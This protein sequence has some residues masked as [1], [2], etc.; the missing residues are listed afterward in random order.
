MNNSDAWGRGGAANGAKAAIVSDR[1][2]MCLGCSDSPGNLEEKVSQ[3]ETMLKKLQDDLQKVPWL[4][5]IFSSFK[6]RS[7]WA[8][9]AEPAGRRVD[10]E[11]WKEWEDASSLI[12]APV[13]LSS[14]QL[15]PCRGS[16]WKHSNSLYLSLTLLYIYTFSDSL[17]VLIFYIFIIYLW[18]LL[19]CFFF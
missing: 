16:Q 13:S 9:A 11:G 19:E 12:Q 3:L 14:R 1:L 5:W 7:E 15:R 17:N 2:W 4:S 18:Q 8:S 6:N 10:L